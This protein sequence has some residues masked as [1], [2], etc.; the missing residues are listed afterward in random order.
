VPKNYFV[1]WGMEDK[2]LFSYAKQELLKM[3]EMDQPFAFTMLTVDTHHIGGYNCDLCD[4]TYEET[5]ENAIACSSRQVLEFVQWLQAQDFYENTTVIIAGDHFSMDREYFSRN[6]DEDYVR[7]GYNCFINSAV[8]TN[9]VKNRQ[10][11]ALDMFPTTLAAMGCT[12]EGNRLGLG[13]NL[14]AGIPTLIEKRGYAAFWNELSMS[15]EYY[16][17]F[18]ETAE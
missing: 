4:D 18:Y 17:R 3:A 8:S 2:H 11:S 12:I 5:Y 15:S 9:R 14:F 7:H 10:F 13:T 6:V 16:Q 1:W